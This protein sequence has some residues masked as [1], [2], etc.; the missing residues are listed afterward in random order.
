MIFLK[1]YVPKRCIIQ[2]KNCWKLWKQ[3]SIYKINLDSLALINW[4]DKNKYGYKIGC[5]TGKT[6]HTCDHSMIY[7]YIG[8]FPSLFILFLNHHILHIIF[9]LGT[10]WASDKIANM[11][12]IFQKKIFIIHDSLLSMWTLLYEKFLNMIII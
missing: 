11:V 3:T 2:S 12:S 7:V 6:H 8:R 9:L 5:H 1:L 4:A 10:I